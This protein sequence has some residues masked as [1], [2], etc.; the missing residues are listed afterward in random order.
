[1]CH[2]L[3]VLPVIALPVF[4]VWPLSI[5][6]P[7]YALAL[8]VALA[9]YALAVMTMRRPVITGSEGLLG[10]SARV[11]QLEGRTATLFLHGELWTAQ[12]EGEA[13]S[14]GD[15]AVVVGIEGLRL[16]ARKHAALPPAKRR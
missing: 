11:L 8:A 2:L 12:V 7:V 3:L 13:L 16:K 1:M 5:A 14:V 6:L 10:E 9:V 4:W 15:T